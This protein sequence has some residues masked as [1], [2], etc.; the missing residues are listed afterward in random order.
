MITIR[1]LDDWFR[2]HEEHGGVPIELFDQIEALLRNWIPDILDA[3]DPADA[4]TMART[5]R[6]EVE[7]LLTGPA[8]WR[9]SSRSRLDDLE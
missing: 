2:E 8:E 5:L 4:G 3:T 7:P 1:K 6:L 9:A